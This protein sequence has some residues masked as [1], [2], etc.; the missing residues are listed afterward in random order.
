MTYSIIGRCSQCGGN[1]KVF[2]GAWMGTQPPTPCCESCGATPKNTLPV[3]QMNEPTV[4]PRLG[5]PYY[6]GK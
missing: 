1:V 5:H 2:T 3:I 4:K 6:N